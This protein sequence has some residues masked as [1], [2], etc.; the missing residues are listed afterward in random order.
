MFEYFFGESFA[1][2]FYPSFGV[3]L[4]VSLF[5]EGL[6][7]LPAAFTLFKVA[8]YSLVQFIIDFYRS[9][10]SDVILTTFAW[11]FPCSAN[12]LEVECFE[13]F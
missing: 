4:V 1:I 2:I 13:T 9:A 5:L 8:P 3:S 12:I 6:N 7:I 11:N 10:G